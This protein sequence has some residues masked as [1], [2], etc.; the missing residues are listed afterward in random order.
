MKR[1]HK[2][3]ELDNMTKRP[4]STSENN[5]C[6]ASFDATMGFAGIVQVTLR[7]RYSNQPRHDCLLRMAYFM[8][9]SA[10]TQLCS[11]LDPQL[12]FSFD[13]TLQ[14]TVEYTTAVST[15]Y[16][17]AD[18]LTVPIHSTQYKLKN[19]EKTALEACAVLCKTKQDM[20]R[21]SRV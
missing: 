19:V 6:L 18:L 9:L 1:V 20:L 7:G 16:L 17:L 21:L 11:C 14:A 4:K 12:V 10:C 5:A 3:S 15:M 8:T 2:Y 13:A